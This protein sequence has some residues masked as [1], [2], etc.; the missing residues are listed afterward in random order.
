MR[1]EGTCLRRVFFVKGNTSG[2]QFLLETR[3][4][5]DKMEHML[6]PW[7]LSSTTYWK[8]I[9]ICTSSYE[10]HGKSNQ[11][12]DSCHLLYIPTLN[13]SSIGI[14]GETR[15]KLHRSSSNCH[16]AGNAVTFWLCECN[17]HL[18]YGWSWAIFGRIPHS[19]PTIP[20]L[21]WKFTMQKYVL[22]QQ[23]PNAFAKLLG[24]LGVSVWPFF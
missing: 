19:Q 15:K 11:R 16:V 22:V 23:K 13:I 24:D 5:M 21:T 14:S 2:M 3:K 20:T 1:I 7:Y 8:G 10:N 6:K 18:F 9:L 4:N 17:I 12:G